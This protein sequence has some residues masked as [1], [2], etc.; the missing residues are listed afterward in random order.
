MLLHLGGRSYITKALFVCEYIPALTVMNLVNLCHDE[1][2]LTIIRAY[3]YTS[4]E[5]L[6][7]CTC[8][9]LFF[10]DYSFL[11]DA[12]YNFHIFNVWQDQKEEEE[13]YKSLSFPNHPSDSDPDTD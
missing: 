4:E 9:A 13:Y 11:A 8:E 1:V 12:K 6:L 5:V 7:L 10:M 3:L 2:S